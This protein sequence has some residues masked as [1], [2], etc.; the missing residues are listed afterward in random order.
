MK[1]PQ[2]LFIALFL[3][4]FSVN[5]FSPFTVNDD[6]IYKDIEQMNL[7]HL[8]NMNF[9]VNTNTNYPVLNSHHIFIRL[10]S[11]GGT[12]NL[13]VLAVFYGILTLLGL[14]L[15]I[16]AYG[17]NKYGWTNYL[18]A[19][20]LALVFA[21]FSYAGYFKSLYPSAFSASFMALWFGIFANIYK[22]GNKW[23]KLLLLSAVTLIFGFAGTLNAV[24]S[25][26]M[27]IV[28]IRLMS[29]SK[30]K[31][32]K[33]LS[34]GLG[35]VTVI[36]SVMFAVTYKGADYNRNIYNSV[37]LGITLNDKVESIGLDPKLNELNGVFYY[38]DLDEEYDLENTL[39]SKVSYGTI[40]K[41]YAT[42]LKQAF[43][44]VDRSTKNAF[45]KTYHKAYLGLY[46]QLKQMFLPNT[47]IFIFAFLFV[48]LG[49]LIYL[50]KIN[51]D[52]RMLLE[53]FIAVSL[54]GITSLKLPV[55]LCGIF[56]LSKSLFMFNL[57]FDI[58][59]VTILVGGSRVMLEKRDEAKE[60]FGVTQ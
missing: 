42:H 28:V 16:K 11:L 32:L 35:L 2:I 39:Y 1:K 8:D 18:L 59:F 57:I 48:F 34:L 17:D 60:K 43:D 5:I 55:F 9:A 40:I 15:V 10:L 13:N 20:L 41:Y 4:I 36:T 24:I 21:D 6:I 3:I 50:Y 14:W 44:M 27:G 29:V 49:V 45:F 47:M 54:T 52:R 46:S 38:E 31:I 7:Y 26:F 53:M 58:I 22:N 37:F 19:V 51:K 25:A 30:D 12:L 23:Y 33:Y 56:E